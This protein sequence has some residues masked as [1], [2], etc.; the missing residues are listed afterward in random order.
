MPSEGTVWF[1][2]HSSADKAFARQ[3]HASLSAVRISCFLDEIDI[4][5]G[6][7]IPARVFD[8]IATTTHFL[9]VISASSIAS[10]WA[11]EELAAAQ[12]RQLDH[13][14][15]VVLPVL[16]EGIEVPAQLRHLR[17]ADFQSW[18]EPAR[19]RSALQDLLRST[20]SEVLPAGGSVVQWFLRHRDPMDASERV[21]AYVAGLFNTPFLMSDYR[22]AG[23]AFRMA[24]KHSVCGTQFEDVLEFLEETL[25]D[26][27]SSVTRNLE[28]LLREVRAAVKQVSFSS[29]ASEYRPLA[30]GIEALLEAL[31]QIRRGVDD[32]VFGLVAIA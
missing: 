2:S 25:E 13:P 7:S 15:S 8:S 6:D 24:T 16:L 22:I 21:L 9:F 18:Q 17:Y 10:Q 12:M 32:A 3:L 4:K 31:R 28:G 23:T 11:M 14:E 5:V 27:P 19:Y 29:E 20:G 26:A 30:V 1:L